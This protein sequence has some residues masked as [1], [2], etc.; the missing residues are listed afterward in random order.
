MATRNLYVKLS[1]I[2]QGKEILL[3]NSLFVIWLGG[4][5]L[6]ILLSKLTGNPQLI[7]GVGGRIWFSTCILIGVIYMAVASFNPD[8]DPVDKS[9]KESWA[10]IVLNSAIIMAVYV[11]FMND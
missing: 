10:V 7:V 1:K 3:K 2:F 8:R 9:P 4:L 5:L 6:I 11:W